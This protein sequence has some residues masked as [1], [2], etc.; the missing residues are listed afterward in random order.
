MS[1]SERDLLALFT[2][3]GIRDANGMARHAASVLASGQDM[4]SATKQYALASGMAG[5]LIANRPGDAVALWQK[6]SSDALRSGFDMNLRL[7]YAYAHAAKAA[8][9]QAQ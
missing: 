7:L 1:A 5:N 8:T 4:S 6:H 3:V 2:A 9:E